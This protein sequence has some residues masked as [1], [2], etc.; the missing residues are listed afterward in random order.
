MRYLWGFTF[1]F[2]YLSLVTEIKSD[3]KVTLAWDYSSGTNDISGCF[4]YQGTVS[5]TY[6]YKTNVG[7]TATCTLS[8]L[9][10]GVTYY[11]VVT[12]YNSSGMESEPSQEISYTVQ[13]LS[14]PPTITPIPDQEIDE[15]RSTTNINFKIN[16]P[17][18][19]IGLLTVIGYSSVNDLVPIKGVILGGSNYDRTIMVVPQTA[20]FG[21]NFISVF[22]SDGANTVTRTFTLKVNPVYYPN[23]QIQFEAESAYLVP[24]MSVHQDETASGGKFISGTNGESGSAV[25][26]VQTP[27]PDQ[28][29]IWAR[30]LSP[31]SGLDSFYV[32]KND[33]DL[34]VYDTV[35][36]FNNAW[37][38]TQVNGRGGTNAPFESAFSID[39][40]IFTMIGF[41]KITFGCREQGTALDEILITNDKNLVPRTPPAPANLKLTVE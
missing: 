2:A 15:N 29:V 19:P 6:T 11:F 7:N 3:Q 5:R 13:R 34:D 38:W 32:S 12:T 36:V 35:K 22:V 17:D 37:Q 26:N 1:L 10:H 28:Y 39:P 41:N 16:D 4:V 30:V 25:F 18:T 8:N 9:L 14:D 21:S 20:K 23:V 33:Q 24:P 27:F 31:N 40:R